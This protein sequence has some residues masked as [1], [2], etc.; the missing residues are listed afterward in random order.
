MSIQRSNGSNSF[1]NVDPNVKI[2]LK[3]FSHLKPIN[4]KLLMTPM[5]LFFKNASLKVMTTV[6]F[7]YFDSF[8]HFA[9][10]K[11]QN[12]RQFLVKKQKSVIAVIIFVSK[13]LHFDA[14]SCSKLN[15]FCIMALIVY[16]YY[17]NNRLK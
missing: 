13:D 5:L 8:Q 12:L 3:S 7:G 1:L 6:I 14:K 17:Q 4:F 2:F 11:L 9:S 15:F 10:T 16:A